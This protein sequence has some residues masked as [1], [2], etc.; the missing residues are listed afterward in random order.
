MSV[1]R[2]VS[3]LLDKGTFD[4]ISL[5]S[6]K[7]SQG[8]RIS[9]RY[10]SSIKP[11]LEDGGLFLITSCNWTEEELRSWLEKEEEGEDEIFKFRD[12]IK[13]P[14]FQFGGKEGQSV[15]TLCFEKKTR[16]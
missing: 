14:R 5:S 8:R 11:F 2:K 1:G 13:Y 16:A 6:E 7:D 9:E 3:V 12:R 10:R 4:A 15:V